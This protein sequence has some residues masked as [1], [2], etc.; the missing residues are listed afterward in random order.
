MGDFLDKAKDMAS[1]IKDK[2]GDVAEKKADRFHDVIPD[3]VPASFEETLQVGNESEAGPSGSDAPEASAD[4][5]N[6]DF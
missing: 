4:S 2:V 3:I 6:D 1:D 5:P